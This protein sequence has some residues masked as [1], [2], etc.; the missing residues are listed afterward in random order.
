MVY[1]R[2]LQIEDI[3]FINTWRNDKEIIDSLGANFRYINKQTDLN[4]FNNY[5]N[6]RNSQVRCSICLK[7]NNEIIG[8]VSLTAIDN[9]NG[10]AEFHI[11]IGNKSYHNKGVGS[12]AT[13]ELLNH[14]F[15]NLNLNKIYLS[16]L[17][18]NSNALRLYKKVGFKE[19]GVLRQ[20]VY[21][22]G[23]YK[24]LI[25][26]SLLKSEYIA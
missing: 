24:D 12:L 20:H 18:D 8:L 7:E 10:T 22:N 11:M 13:R 26:M 21:K 15:N 23:C 17:E 3:D 5:Q 16:V 4:W 6:N 1:L 25:I 9:L 14:G 19:D 2:E